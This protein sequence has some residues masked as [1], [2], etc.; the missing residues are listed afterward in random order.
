MKKK[1]I[2]KNDDFY[3]NEKDQI[4]ANITTNKQKEIPQE[5]MNKMKLISPIPLN[6]PKRKMSGVILV[7]KDDEIDDE[8]NEKQEDN[9]SSSDE[10]EDNKKIKALSKN[11]EKENLNRTF[12]QKNDSN[13]DW[14]KNIS[15]Y[16]L[17]LKDHSIQNKNNSIL[18]YYGSTSNYLKLKFED[19]A[20][21]NEGNNHNFI[22]K[23]ID[24]E[25][26]NNNSNLFISLLLFPELFSLLYLCCSSL[27]LLKISFKG[28][29]F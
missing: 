11:N 10:E 24:N 12:T 13:F 18:S 29:K 3:F 5:L 8:F 19:N 2:E 14:R 9:F 25:K 17:F 21:N 16:D 4:K 20:L 7:E 22:A 6:K 1:N 27:L 23:K 28:N 15:G 26:K